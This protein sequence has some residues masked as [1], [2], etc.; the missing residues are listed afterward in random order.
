MNTCPDC[1]HSTIQ[2]TDICPKCHMP[3]AWHNDSQADT[4]LAAST[5]K[6][7][8]DAILFSTTLA[9]G[10]FA[11]LI[12]LPILGELNATQIGFAPG[13]F[14][15]GLALLGLLLGVSGQLRIL[16]AVGALSVVLVIATATSAY[17]YM[18]DSKAQLAAGESLSQLAAALI[19]PTWGWIPLLAGAI[20]LLAVGKGHRVLRR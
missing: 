11:P 9:L 4:D 7:T 19:Y 13:Y 6:P 12:H 16:Q 5:A 20:G 3:Y 2:R 15:L 14:L 10:C 17:L 8:L 18:S 1:G